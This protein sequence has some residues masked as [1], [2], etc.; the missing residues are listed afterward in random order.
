MSKY[1]VATL[2]L[3][4]QPSFLLPASAQSADPALGRRIAETTCVACHQIDAKPAP[5]T[6][7]PVAPSFV[8]VARMPSTTELSI[9]VFLRT[10]HKSMPN[11]M[12]S[13]EEIDSLAAYVVGLAKQ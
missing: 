12:L 3:V 8:D 13:P 4:I 10:S 6:V 1:F 2:A 11:F 5:Q 7:K 9:K